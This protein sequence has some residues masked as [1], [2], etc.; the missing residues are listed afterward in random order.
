MAKTKKNDLTSVGEMVTQLE[1]FSIIVY[2]N[3][4]RYGTWK[5]SFL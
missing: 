5:N 1:L 4:K 3:A 2:M